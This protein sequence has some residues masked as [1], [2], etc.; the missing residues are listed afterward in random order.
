MR[1]AV[2]G[3][4]YAG[5]VAV[6]RLERRLPEA[7]EL[8]FVDPRPDHL[9]KHELHRVVRRPRVGEAIR[10]PFG[11]ILDRARIREER[12]LDL[13]PDAGRAVFESDETLSYDAAVVAIGARPA[14][15]GLPG[16]EAHAMPL[17]SIAHATAIGDRMETL[18]DRGRGTAVVGGAGLAG[19]QV[20]GELAA[21]ADG[22]EVEVHLLE[23]ADRVAPTAAPRL[24]SALDERLRESGVEVETDQT[25]SRATEAAV[26]LAS[27]RRVEYDLLVWTGGITGREA[28][29]GNRPIVRADL[30][31]GERTFAAG[32][33]V[34]A[35]DQEGDMAAA[36]A[37]A[38]V[39]MAPVAADN[40]KRRAVE[41]SRGFGP[42]Y[43]RYR[44]DTSGLVV[45]VGDETVA[46]V[47]PS[48]LTGSPAKAL[49]SL[50]GTRYLSTAGAVAEGVSVART[51]FGL[52]GADGA[53]GD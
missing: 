44:E 3:G 23:Q 5:L 28:F 52:A 50:V 42:N 31:L 41:G 12:V 38:A 14:F 33:A 26:E 1:V 25:V 18:I 36:T 2:F 24:S 10:I 53:A 46:K 9:V 19:I 6:T 32:D 37:Q 48:I 39:G 27:G 51:E 21:M 30:K 20:A 8:V 40:A 7:A 29:G 16:V 45:S 43:R 11:S 35:V 49:K 4:G 17:D 47:G 15:Y 34:R 13:D 22:T